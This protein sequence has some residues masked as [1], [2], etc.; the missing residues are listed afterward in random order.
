MSSVMPQTNIEK[1]QLVIDDKGKRVF[2]GHCLEWVWH[3]YAEQHVQP[4]SQVLTIDN[5]TFVTLG[6]EGRDFFAQKFM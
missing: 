2:S 3:R 6:D 5:F 1:I 4:F